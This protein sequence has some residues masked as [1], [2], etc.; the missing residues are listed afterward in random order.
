VIVDW[1]LAPA[2]IAAGLMVFVGAAATVQPS[3][4]ERV[5]VSATTPLGRSE[6]RAVFGGML[7]ALGLACLL[8]RE[9]VV[10]GV[11][12]AAWLADVAVRLGAVFADRIPPKEA[13]AV[14]AIGT[15]MGVALLSGYWLA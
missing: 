9:P 11:V 14:L 3:V 15:A 10:F 7:L 2:M 13:A 8:L 6:L 4:V 12:G 5:G 1:Q